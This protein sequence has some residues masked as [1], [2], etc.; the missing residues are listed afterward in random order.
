M[1]SHA[2][3]ST[4]RRGRRLEKYEVEVNT[5]GMYYEVCTFT[6]QYPSPPTNLPAVG[7]LA[8][9]NQFGQGCP[10]KGKMSAD[11]CLPIMYLT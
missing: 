1:T 10:G 7:Q 8:F 9:A 11:P 3:R 2:S 5:V 6:V 4:E